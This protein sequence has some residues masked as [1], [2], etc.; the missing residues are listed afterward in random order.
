M[1]GM[2]QAH[3]IVFVIKVFQFGRHCQLTT[4]QAIFSTI[5]ELLYRAQCLIAA[6]QQF[7]ELR[8]VGRADCR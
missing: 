1:H 2:H 3:H 5:N 4:N 7:F 8:N 6:T